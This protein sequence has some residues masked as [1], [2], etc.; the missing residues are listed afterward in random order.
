MKNWKWNEPISVANRG[1]LTSPPPRAAGMLSY[2]GQPDRR[3][4]RIR[5]Y[6]SD[7]ECLEGALRRFYLSEKWVIK[8]IHFGKAHS[9]LD[10]QMFT[11]PNTRYFSAA[12]ATANRTSGF[13]PI[14]EGWRYCWDSVGGWMNRKRIS[15]TSDGSCSNTSSRSV[16]TNG[17]AVNPAE[18]ASRYFLWILNNTLSDDSKVISA[19]GSQTDVMWPLVYPMDPMKIKQIQREERV[20]MLVGDSFT[21]GSDFAEG[22]IVLVRRRNALPISPCFFGAHDSM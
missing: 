2:A 13:M 1:K 4:R 15:R 20:R 21:E 6:S 17:G 19:S 18:V 14:I 16:S 9:I 11:V 3:A 22:S 7:L 8:R 12:S 10:R 5:V